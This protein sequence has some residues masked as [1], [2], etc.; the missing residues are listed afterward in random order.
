MAPASWAWRR[1]SRG[2]VA[3][4]AHRAHADGDALA[5]AEL[6]QRPDVAGLRAAPAAGA[7]RAA[8]RGRG[9]RAPRPRACAAASRRARRPRATGAA[10]SPVATGRA[11]MKTCGRSRSQPAARAR[12][13]AMSSAPSSSASKSARTRFSAVRRSMCSALRSARAAWLATACSSSWCCAG[14]VR[15][16]RAHGDERADL[17]AIVAQRGPRLDV[18]IGER[19]G[20]VEGD[21]LERAVLAVA[22]PQ[23]ARR[24]SPAAGARPR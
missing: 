13:S 12:A 9:R 24:R 18:R 3:A 10:S 4:A 23:L 6:A 11:W 2:A 5:R 21:Q 16:P 1:L 22:Q 17:L 7:G 14:K 20:R 8:R 19:A 15:T